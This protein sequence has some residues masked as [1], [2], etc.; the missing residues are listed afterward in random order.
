MNGY[1]TAG[2]DNLLV[3]AGGATAA[4]S[5]VTLAAGTGGGL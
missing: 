4:L 2:W 1:A 5:G 3:C